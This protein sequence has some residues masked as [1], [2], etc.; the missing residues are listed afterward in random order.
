MLYPYH[1]W[2]IRQLQNA[3]E[4]PDTMLPLLESLLKEPSKNNADLFTECVLKF[5]DW[6]KPANGNDGICTQFFED[7]EWNWHHLAIPVEDR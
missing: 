6:P 7:C 3:P 2:F 4:K 1:K 5:R